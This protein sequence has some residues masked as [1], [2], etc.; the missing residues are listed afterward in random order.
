MPCRAGI[1]APQGRRNPGPPTTSGAAAGTQ[2]PGLP[3]ARGAVAAKAA[4]RRRGSAPRRGPL[5]RRRDHERP[6][7]CAVSVKEGL[8]QDSEDKSSRKM[9]G[10]SLYA[11]CMHGAQ[12]I[13]L[14]FPFLLSQPAAALEF[15]EICEKGSPGKDLESPEIQIF[16]R[17][18]RVSRHWINYTQVL[19]ICI[20]S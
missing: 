11:M 17:T 12:V 7:L 6:A 20:P 5:R 2:A 9:G 14:P 18:S 10:F 1:Q 19:E 3:S 16:R 15:V 8:D 13:M 4:G